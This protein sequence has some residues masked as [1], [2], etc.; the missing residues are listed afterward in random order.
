MEYKQAIKII[1]Q[2]EGAEIIADSRLVGFL[3]DYQAFEN[4]PYALNILRQIY[5]YNYGIQI[6]NAYVAKDI[7][8]INALKKSISYKFG[9][10]YN[11]VSKIFDG[12]NYVFGVQLDSVSNTTFNSQ[13]ST[14]NIP[15]TYQ[16][17][18]TYQ[19][20][21]TYK[22]PSYDYNSYYD[23]DLSKYSKPKNYDRRVRRPPLSKSKYHPTNINEPKK[24]VNK[25]PIIL[26]IIAVLLNIPAY[27]IHPWWGILTTILSIL[28]LIC[29]YDE[30]SDL[31]FGIYG[32]LIL[33]FITIFTPIP[34]W[35][36]LIEIIVFII[37]CLIYHG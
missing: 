9:F 37:L 14:Q 11:K 21:S 33:I 24:G 30:E 18:Q 5:Q 22:D 10:A 3:S 17:Q 34:W 13:S 27:I 36:L 28:A 16:P 29:I 7:M 6:Y 12:F 25:I 4:M 20:Q 26:T 32:L 23:S 35:I 8:Q 2:Q 31:T 15:P 1:I 19:P